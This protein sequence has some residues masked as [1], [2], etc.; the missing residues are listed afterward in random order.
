MHLTAL[1]TDF[2][3]TVQ[4]PTA[5]SRN[6]A[7]RHTPYMAAQYALAEA[8]RRPQS[9]ATGASARPANTRRREGERE[10]LLGRWFPKISYCRVGALVA[11]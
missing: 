10:P 6:L 1:A 7:N 11:N 8:E 4:Y 3:L 5:Q 9:T 2:Y